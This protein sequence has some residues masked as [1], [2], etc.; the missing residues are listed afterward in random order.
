M[1]ESN[2]IPAPKFSSLLKEL[3]A[4]IRIL[5]SSIKTAKSKANF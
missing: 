3:D 5:A 1:I 2:V 4:I